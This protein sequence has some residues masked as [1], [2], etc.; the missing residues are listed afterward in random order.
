MSNP[1][2]KERAH[3][4]KEPILRSIIFIAVKYISMILGR[5]IS[6]RLG[7]VK[8]SVHYITKT[9]I[10]DPEKLIAMDGYQPK[11]QDVFV[12]TYFKSGTNWMLQIAQQI[13]D[14]GDST[15]EHI[16]D[17]VANPEAGVY[18]D[19]NVKPVYQSPS[20]LRVIKTHQSAP[21]IPYNESAKYLVVLRSPKEVLVSSYHFFCGILN[22]LPYI[23]FEEWAEIFMAQDSLLDRWIEHTSS[24]WAWRDRSNV[25]VVKF[26]Q[27]KKQ[28]EEEI[29]TIIALLEIP[30]NEQQLAQVIE[31]ASFKYMK[32][33]QD[34]FAPARSP[35]I[36]KDKTT[37]MMRKGEAGSKEAADHAALL[38]SIDKICQQK[39]DH[40]GSDF[41]YAE[42][43]L[44]PPK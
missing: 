1:V 21:Y 18:P 8:F 22:V 29:K 32:T 26:D 30:L 24:Y 28:P 11:K 37:N 10:L 43:F 7:L 15:F 6:Q 12:A 35:F 41:P 16:H 14:Y 40:M 9:V 3:L 34:K 27:L 44:P 36:A 33:Q 25:Y 4:V 39:L 38:A 20:G 13:A 5:K 23:S 19:L 31:R 17:V 42:W 2:N